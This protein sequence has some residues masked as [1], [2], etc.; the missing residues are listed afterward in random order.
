MSAT[1]TVERLYEY[2]QGKLDLE[3]VGGKA[4]GQ[5]LIRSSAARRA[6]VPLVGHLNF[7]HG[8]QVQVLGSAELRYL[9]ELGKNSYQD[10][11]KR[12]FAPAISLVVIAG[13]RPVM[14]EL[15]QAAEAAAMPLFSSRLPSQQVISDLQ[16]YLTTL[17]AEKLTLHGVFMEVMGIG[18]LITG[19]S[20]VGKS[21]LALE[22][23]SRGHRLIADD[24]PEFS[25]IAP[26]IVS[27]S[28]PELLRDFLEVRGLGFLNVRA[29]FGD[30]VTKQSKYLR[31]MIR[32]QPMSERRLERIDRL[33]GSRRMRK[34]LGVEV[35]EITLPVASGRNLA[36]LV[37]TAVRD[38]ILKLKGYDAGL[39]F[40]TQQQ[41]MM[42]QK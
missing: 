30:S 36:V 9:R 34:V 21:E 41:R 37:E 23:L 42:E 32:L 1:I 16:Y 26:D 8:N 39:D 33:E 15:R 25:R 13:S 29:M 7:I 19:A 38:H 4:G 24:A 40:I 28:C 10:A 11:M 17:L 27:G 6:A 5:R 3:W 20:G 2:L 18:V 14:R 31:L 12:L 35:P 22:L